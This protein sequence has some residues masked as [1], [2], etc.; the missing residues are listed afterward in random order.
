MRS[1]FYINNWLY[2]GMSVHHWVL[3]HGDE[4]LSPGRHPGRRDSVLC[5]DHS[6]AVTSGNGCSPLSY[7]LPRQG[8]ERTKELKS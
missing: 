4:I 5:W 7:V 2:Y 1:W 8:P 6:Q 3:H